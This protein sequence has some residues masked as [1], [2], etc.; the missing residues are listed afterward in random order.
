MNNQ[1]INI[2]HMTPEMF[3]KIVGFSDRHIGKRYYSIGDLWEVYGQSITEFGCSSFV[4]LDGENIVGI[5]LTRNHGT[6][7]SG[8]KKVRFELWKTSVSTAAYF[9]SLFLHPD[10]QGKGLG[11]ELSLKSIEVLKKAGAKSIIT[12][13]HVESPNNSSFKYLSK[14]G[15]RGIFT[16]EQYWAEIDYQCSSC[17][18]RPCTCSATEMVL[19]LDEL[20]MTN[21]PK[22]DLVASEIEYV[23]QYTLEA[24][25]T[26]LRKDLKHTQDFYSVRLERI[27][28]LFRKTVHWRDVACIFANATIDPC[29]SPYYSQVLA[30]RGHE[31]KSLETKLKESNMKTVQFQAQRNAERENNRQLDKDITLLE[32]TLKDKE[33]LIKLLRTRQDTVFFKGVGA[34]LDLAIKGLGEL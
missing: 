24:E 13:S 11:K 34:K 17:N 32:D 21:F 20:D 6:G 2:V 4:A 8:E 27:K 18:F 12:H 5:R 26:G 1:S 9:Q 7:W 23:N 15:F 3:P 29:E 33:D 28:D 22:S 16:H 31:I 19:M 25:I 30:T 14:L 10:Y